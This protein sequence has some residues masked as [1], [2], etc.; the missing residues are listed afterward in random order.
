[1]N[2][3]SDLLSQ[4]I[5]DYIAAFTGQYGYPISVKPKSTSALM[6]FIGWFFS[7]TKISPRFMDHYITTIGNTVYIP[8]DML[9]NPNNAASLLRVIVHE[10]IH[11]KDSNRL[12]FFGLL[13]KFLYLFP[14]SLT[15]LAL[16]SFLAF[17]KIG[18]LRCLLF[19]VCAAPIPAP[20]RYLFE[21]RAYRTQVLFSR[22]EDGLTTDT[23]VPVCQW[24]ES[25]MT[26]SLYYWTWPFPKAIR[27]QL[28]SETWLTEPEYKFITRWIVVRNIGKQ[29]AAVSRKLIT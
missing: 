11:I 28:L 19:L 13:F 14:Q 5:K 23:L 29:M 3:S 7:V 17:W 22:K 20:F 15:P 16:L 2:T 21:L 4:D 9:S 24:I 12:L 25:Q 26:T 8:D 18:F 10:S 1:M 27:P 6:R